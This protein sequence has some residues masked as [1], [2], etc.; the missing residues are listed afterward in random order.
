MSLELECSIL[1]PQEENSGLE[2]TPDKTIW[3]DSS[4]SHK[5]MSEQ[6]RQLAFISLPEFQERVPIIDKQTNFNYVWHTDS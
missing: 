6:K 3:L 2:G 1:C 5:Q 4:S